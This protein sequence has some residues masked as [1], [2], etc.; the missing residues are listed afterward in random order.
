MMKETRTYNG[1]KRASS[2]SG[3]RKTGQ[4]HVKELNQITSLP[5][6]SLWVI[7]LFIKRDRVGFLSL[8]IE[9]VLSYIIYRAEN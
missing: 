8:I 3:V 6:S 5:I 7:S 1:D 4:L 9:R 2:I